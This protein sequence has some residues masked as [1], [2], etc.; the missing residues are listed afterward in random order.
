MK[1]L[2][3]ILLVFAS[4]NTYAQ[5]NLIKFED[6]DGLFGY[7]DSLKNVIVYPKYT[8]ASVFNQ[9]LALVATNKGWNIIDHT[10]K[11]LT[12]FTG[13][14]KFSYNE[15]IN[16][17]FIAI[18]KN[19]KWGFIDRKGNLLIPYQYEEVEDFNMGIAPVKIGELWGFI[20]TDNELIIKPTYEKVTIFYDGLAGFYENGKWGFINGNNEVVI[21]PKY[22]SITLFSEGLCA[23]NTLD[24]NAM[25]GGITNEVINKKGEIV[26][27]GEFWAFT[28]Y[29]N[30]VASYWEGYDFRGK[31]IFI[32]RN[33]KRIK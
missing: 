19:E 10:G 16:Y 30:G 32:D 6:K 4:L 20:N 25:G 12:D 5:K 17:E 11:E 9:G 14:P 8:I 2:V 31:H 26:F 21:E 33:G 27:T 1:K 7:K 24:F 15:Y 22:T 13:T 29:K 23:V 3:Y 28:P 18:K